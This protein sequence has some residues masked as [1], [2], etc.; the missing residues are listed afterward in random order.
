M[1]WSSSSQTDVAFLDMVPSG[2]GPAGA[3]QTAGGGGKQHPQCG[4]GGGERGQA[5]RSDHT[6][7][8]WCPRGISVWKVA[9]FPFETFPW[10]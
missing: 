6:L 2:G 3:Q 9:I 8:G 7:P 4:A 10:F 1:L 5:C